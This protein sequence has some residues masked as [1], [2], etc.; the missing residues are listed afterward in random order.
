[1]HNPLVPIVEEVITAKLPALWGLS[2]GGLPGLH[3]LRRMAFSHFGRD[4]SFF[5]TAITT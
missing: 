3:N 2:I 1:L 4:V 5:T